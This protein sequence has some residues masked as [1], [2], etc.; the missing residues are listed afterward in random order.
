VHAGS[1]VTH[2]SGKDFGASKGQ[3]RLRQTLAVLT[4]MFSENTGIQNPNWAL[5]HPRTKTSTFERFQLTKFQK[6]NL[7]KN[8]TTNNSFFSVAS[9][10]I[11]D[12]N[13]CVKDA[14][15]TKC[16]LE[17]LKQIHDKEQHSR[18][19]NGYHRTQALSLSAYRHYQEISQRVISD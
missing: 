16:V 18:M 6:K 8:I 7:E 3:C 4:D 14:E 11:A 2:A 19:Y 12:F 9:R 17:I 10:R 5:E 13:I 15:L 1:C